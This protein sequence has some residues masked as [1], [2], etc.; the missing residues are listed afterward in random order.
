MSRYRCIVADPPWPQKGRGTLRGREGWHDAQGASQP[1]RYELMSVEQI[2]APSGLPYVIENVETAPLLDPV[3]ETTAGPP[4]AHP[5]ALRIGRDRH[6]AALIE[7]QGTGP[8][9]V[10]S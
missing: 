4:G 10:L 1:M 8:R 3:L 2:A 5:G 6:H 7:D 9:G